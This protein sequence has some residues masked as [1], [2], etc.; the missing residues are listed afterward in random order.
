MANIFQR[1]AAIDSR[2]PDP[3]VP[4]AYQTKLFRPIVIEFWPVVTTFPAESLFSSREKN[5]K[6][7]E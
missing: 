2:M 4:L 1:A 6:R 3:G 5:T 7:F